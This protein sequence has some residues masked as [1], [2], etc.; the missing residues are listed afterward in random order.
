MRW[1]TDAQKVIGRMACLAAAAG[2]PNITAQDMATALGKPLGNT[3]E[4]WSPVPETP[5]FVQP[6][7]VAPFDRAAKRVLERSV[8]IALDRGTQHLGTEHFAAAL[9]HH[10]PP[11]VAAW[12]AAHG[13]TPDR[14][15][16]LVAGLAGGTGVEQLAEEPLGRTWSPN[17]VVTSLLTT[18]GLIAAA[19]VV[20]VLCIWGP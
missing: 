20:F 14:V 17:P 8:R 18:A 19:V 9:V 3:A 1:T 2:R 7:T 12:L 11:D 15:D 13:V 6:V 4:L 5:E 10:G 16:A